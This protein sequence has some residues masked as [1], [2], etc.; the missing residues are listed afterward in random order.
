MNDITKGIEGIF[1]QLAQAAADALG[2]FPNFDLS[3]AFNRSAPKA[4][5]LPAPKQ[6]AAKSPRRQKPA[7]D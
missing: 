3:E 7:L 6:N 2:S 4:I 1:G 5:N